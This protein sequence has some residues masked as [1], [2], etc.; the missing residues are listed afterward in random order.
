MTVSSA[1]EIPALILANRVYF[2]P[3]SKI[4]FRTAEEDWSSNQKIL[5]GVGAAANGGR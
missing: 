4:A 3:W 2:R 1:A 5:T